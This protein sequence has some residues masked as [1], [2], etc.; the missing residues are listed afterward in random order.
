MWIFILFSKNY[1][2]KFQN[3]SFSDVTGINEPEGRTWCSLNT[4]FPNQALVYGGYSNE[5]RALSDFWRV[6]V[7]KDHDGR[8]VGMW[9]EVDT[10]HEVKYRRLWHTGAV[11]EGQLFG[12]IL[13]LLTNFHFSSVKVTTVD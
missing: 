2:V 8:Y 5:A 10:G 9:T 13:L 6:E 4:L 7:K 11:V 12:E 3:K 1:V